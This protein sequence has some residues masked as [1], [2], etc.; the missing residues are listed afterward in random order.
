[1]KGIEMADNIKN[2]MLPIEI[3]DL[4]S[5][6]MGSIMTLVWGAVAALLT[7]RASATA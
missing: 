3:S 1:M 2:V 4:G 7:L 5:P 6:V